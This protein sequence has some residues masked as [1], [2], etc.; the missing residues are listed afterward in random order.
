MPPARR[1]RRTCGR[2]S[3][4]RPAN[5][6]WRKPQGTLAA[7]CWVRL[8]GKLNGVHAIQALPSSSERRKLADV[9]RGR[10]ERRREKEIVLLHEHAHRAAIGAARRRWRRGNPSCESRRPPPPC[11]RRPGSSCALLF[12]RRIAEQVARR[13]TTKSSGISR[14]D[15]RRADRPVRHARPIAR[16]ASPRLRQASST[17]GTMRFD[18]A[19]A[20]TE[21][22]ALAA[23]RRF[24]SR[25]HNPSLRKAANASRAHRVCAMT[26]ISMALSNARRGSSGRHGRRVPNGDSG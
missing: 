2:R 4:G 24:E 12:F 14:R 3:A 15:R 10:R 22:D 17:S 18:I 25:R 7:G 5:R 23:Q 21:R 1:R 6:P 20:R 13:P 19:K 16:S 8:N 9:E 11:W 26:F